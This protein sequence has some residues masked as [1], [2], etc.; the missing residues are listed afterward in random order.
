MRRNAAARRSTP[1]L[2]LMNLCGFE[3]PGIGSSDEE[4]AASER[5][6]GVHF[7]PEYADLLRTH[8]G[9]YGD[10]EFT[11]PD[12]TAAGSIGYWL[13]LSP[14]HRHSLWITLST[15]RTEHDMPH[16]VLPVAYDGGGNCL[17]L[18]YRTS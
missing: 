6:L 13:S 16:T 11:F 4:I 7:P 9:A 2:C 18:D 5:L 10:A 14:W 8:A 15:W 12:S 17:C 1:T 3:S